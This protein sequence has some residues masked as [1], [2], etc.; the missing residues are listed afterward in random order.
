MKLSVSLPDV[1]VRFI[2]EYLARFDAATRSS[3]IQLAIGLLRET[4]MRDE[5][6]QAF[7]EW[8][9]EDDAALWEST[10]ADAPR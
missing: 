8:D 5:Y 4:A 2:D 9:A 1:D 10:V 7:A 6:A 3:V